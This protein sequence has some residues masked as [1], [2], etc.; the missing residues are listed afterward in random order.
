MIHKPHL[1]TTLPIWAPRYSSAYTETN[2]RVA[3]LADYKLRNASPVVLI[4]FTKAEHLKGQR[5][6]IRRDVALSYPLDSNG[7]IACRAVPMSALESWETPQET[8]AILDSL[9]W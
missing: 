4:T 2:E 1:L 7:K 6:C 3:L 9:G 8:T 5:F